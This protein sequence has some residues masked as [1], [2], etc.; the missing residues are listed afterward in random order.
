MLS[1]EYSREN[2]AGKKVLLRLEMSKI[3][4]ELEEV[5]QRKVTF[6]SDEFKFTTG[7]KRT[8]CRKVFLVVKM[9]GKKI[10]KPVEEQIKR[11]KEKVND[12]LRVEKGMDGARP[13]ARVAE[14][15]NEGAWGDPNE[16]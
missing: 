13:F 11:M 1:A 9:L 8:R 7:E 2:A 5:K 3:H 10:G 15:K 6:E 4:T 16:S 14:V 12:L